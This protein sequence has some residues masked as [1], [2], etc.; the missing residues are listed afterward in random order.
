M[1]KS[2]WVLEVRE[3]EDWWCW[4]IYN[5]STPSLRFEA[6]GGYSRKSS[7]KRG[8]NRVAKALR[9]NVGEK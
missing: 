7:A 1:K 3:L 4:R 8:A 5:R 9:I 6:P 2:T